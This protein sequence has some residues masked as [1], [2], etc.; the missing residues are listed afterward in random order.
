MFSFIVDWLQKISARQCAVLQP[1]TRQ[2]WHGRHE[3][4]RRRGEET[5]RG[6]GASLQRRARGMALNGRAFATAPVSTPNKQDGPTRLP[7]LWCT[8]R[9]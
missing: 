2:S 8:C 5:T 3:Q 1:V 6:G 9:R 7:L 4:V